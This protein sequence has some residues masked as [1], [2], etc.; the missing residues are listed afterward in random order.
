MA[1][2]YGQQRN[3]NNNSSLMA[4]PVQG[5]VGAQNYLVAAGNTVLLTDFNSGFIWIKTNDGLFQTLRTFKIE[6][7]TPQPKQNENFIQRAEFEQFQKNVNLQLQQILDSLN[8]VGG[9]RQNESASTDVIKQ[10][11]TTTAKL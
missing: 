10:S 8:N 4:I 7:I 1:D 6:E 3:N 2:Y 5:E 11:K 9:S